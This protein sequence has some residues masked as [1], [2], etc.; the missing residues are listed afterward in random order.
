LLLSI[1]IVNY[2]VKYFIEQCLCSVQKAIT[3]IEAEVFVIDNQSSDGSMDYLPPLFP[4]VTFLVNEKNEGFGKANNRAL[5]IAEGKYV[6]FLNPDTIVPEDCFTCCIHF[7]ESTIPAGGV[8]IRMVDGR[9]KFLPESKRAFPT[10]YACLFKLT[11]LATL[12][13]N[14]KL[15]NRYALGHLDKEK[16]HEVDVLAGA[17]MMV[18][19]KALAQTGGF[20]E[21]FFMYGEDVDLSYRIK[22]AGYKNY[23]LGENCIIHFKGESTPENSFS[24]VWIFYKAMNLFVQKYSRG[25][26]K[27]SIWLIQFAISLKFTVSLLLPFLKLVYPGPTKPF[28]KKS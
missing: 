1:I 24:Q 11:G 2:N 28:H 13:P 22:K 10:L 21:L 15:F 5:Q 18:R 19:K 23:Y 17:F 3:K 6:L 8:G 7:F 14:S 12:F 16:N 25:H 27:I 4:W 20:D 9:G 26:T